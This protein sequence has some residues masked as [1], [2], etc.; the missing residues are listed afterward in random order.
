MQIIENTNEEIATVVEI[1]DGVVTD[2][3]IIGRYKILDPDLKLVKRIKSRT[4]PKL[5]D[6]WLPDVEGLDDQEAETNTLVLYH[7]LNVEGFR[8]VL[9]VKK[10]EDSKYSVIRCKGYEMYYDSHGFRVSDMTDFNNTLNINEYNNDFA[11]VD[12]IADLLNKERK[13]LPIEKDETEEMKKSA[14]SRL[15]KKFKVTETK[16]E[17]HKAKLETDEEKIFLPKVK[18]DL[19]KLLDQ[20][21]NKKIATA[22]DL[23]GAVQLTVPKKYRQ[24]KIL[25]GK[26]AANLD[27]RNFDKKRAAFAE[28]FDGFD[29]DKS[30]AKK[31]PKFLMGDMPLEFQ[32]V[33]V[34]AKTV[35]YKFEDTSYELESHVFY[36]RLA[37]TVQPSAMPTIMKFV[38]GKLSFKECLS[39]Y[40]SHGFTDRNR[41]ESYDINALRDCDNPTQLIKICK[42]L[43]ALNE[44]VDP[45]MIVYKD[46][47]YYD[48]YLEVLVPNEKVEVFFPDMNEFYSGT[49]TSIGH[50]VKIRY[51]ADGEVC[52]LQKSQ[53][54][55]PWK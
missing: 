13:T 30:I 55:E 19:L 10:Y 15:S 47:P 27:R 20:F 28:M 51:D 26:T 38:R 22:K 54:V 53:T 29:F 25:A 36:A 18:K 44:Y 48:R 14:V 24:F 9:K 32:G 21:K 39:M 23:K 8:P 37:L 52:D 40:H 16:P 35:T 7:Y 46:S 41:F 12:A 45:S 2:T 3:G 50:G 33:T 43:M 49:V 11:S 1:V 5:E 6:F 4:A 17:E 31:E 42:R 34:N